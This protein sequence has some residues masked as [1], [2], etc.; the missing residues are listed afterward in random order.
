[1]TQ[2]AYSPHG[3]S[4]PVRNSHIDGSQAGDVYAGGSPVGES[5]IGRLPAAVAL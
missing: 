5:L 3:N 1:M 4:S 2:L